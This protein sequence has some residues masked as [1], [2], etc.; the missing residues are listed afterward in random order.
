MT[1]AEKLD[2]EILAVDRG[3]SETALRLLLRSVHRFR[4]ANSA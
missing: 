1:L 4:I 3:N 2:R